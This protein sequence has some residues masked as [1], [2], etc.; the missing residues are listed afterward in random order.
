[1]LAVPFFFGGCN[2]ATTTDSQR[3]Q[4]L[5]KEN[6]ELKLQHAGVKKSPPEPAPSAHPGRNQRWSPDIF[7]NVFMGKDQ[8]LVK[9]VLG[10]PDKTEGPFNQAWVWTYRG[11]HIFDS[12][13][14]REMTTVQ[15][16]FLDNTIYR[17]Y[18]TFSD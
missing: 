3:L 7:I 14:E 16:R 4:A 1:M 17:D 15:I 5:E 12:V 13:S 9:K 11:M 10:P 8:Q 6:A 2:K 18:I